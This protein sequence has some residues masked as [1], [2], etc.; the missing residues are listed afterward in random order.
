MNQ[1]SESATRRRLLISCGSTKGGTTLGMA[2]VRDRLPHLI[3]QASGAARPIGQRQL[4]GQVP[5]HI[6]TM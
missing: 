3:Q 2:P 1:D 4:G 5:E 6:T